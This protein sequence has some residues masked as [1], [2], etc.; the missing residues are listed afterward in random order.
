MFELVKDGSLDGI[1][2]SV[3]PE[4]TTYFATTKRY[5]FIDVCIGFF[6]GQHEISYREF[7]HEDNIRRYD[8]LLDM[9]FMQKQDCVLV[10][11]SN[12]GFIYKVSD[13]R[14]T[15]KPF[16]FLDEFGLYCTDDKNKVPEN[17]DYTFIPDKGIYF[18]FI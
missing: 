5:Y 6:N 9:G 8:E 12:V 14:I 16:K 17:T 1:Y 3:D 11:R 2:F 7:L 10:I 15:G 18:F 13:R 4:N